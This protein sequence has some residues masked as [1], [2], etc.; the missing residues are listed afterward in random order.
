MRLI[1]TAALGTVLLACGNLSSNHGDGGPDGGPPPGGDSGSGSDSGPG[2]DAG[3]G[4]DGGSPGDAG[5]GDAGGPGDSG[6]SVVPQ[7]TWGQLPQP[8]P[9]P[10]SFS[11]VGGTAAGTGPVQ[12]YVGAET[13]LGLYSGGTWTL[14]VFHDP[15]NFSI[16]AVLVTDAGAVFVAGENFLAYCPSNCSVNGSYNTTSVSYSMES[17]CTGDGSTI[18]ATGYDSVGS[19]LGTLYKFDPLAQSWSQLF[20]DTQTQD[21]WGCW[22][23]P[24]GVVYSAAYAAVSRYDSASQALTVEKLSTFP[25]GFPLTNQQ[26]EWLRGVWGYGST[27][28]AAGASRLIFRRNATGG[29][30]WVFQ[31]PNAS[32]T[33]STFNAMAGSGNEGYAVG[34]S[35]LSWNVARYYD[36][37][38]SIDHSAGGAGL[39]GVTAYSIWSRSSNEYY[40]VGAIPGGNAVLFSGTR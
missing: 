5:S 24:N 21:N 17:L 29:W 6:T 23:D 11:G 2:P 34:D 19:E 40:A 13:N 16:N 4:P 25:A 20:V 1:A 28:F 32:P 3:T 18:Y 15:S 22:V 36:G 31:D 26:S 7:L 33:S 35:F 8:N 10:F 12:L 14:P 27:V 39:D 9:V 37:G 38:W 30:D